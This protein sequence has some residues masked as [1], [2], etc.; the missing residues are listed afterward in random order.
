ME[1]TSRVLISSQIGYAEAIAI[2]SSNA[3][4]LTNQSDLNVHVYQRSAAA[5]ADDVL[6][7]AAYIF[8]VQ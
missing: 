1:P 3:I 4:A 8:Q 6:T 2:N 7:G 5:G